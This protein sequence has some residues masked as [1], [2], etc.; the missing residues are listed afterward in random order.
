[1]GSVKNVLKLKT[2]IVYLN[3]GYIFAT[4]NKNKYYEKIRN[5]TSN[6]NRFNNSS[7]LFINSFST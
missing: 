6:Y 4:T 3:I 1:M 7:G 5:N 2:S